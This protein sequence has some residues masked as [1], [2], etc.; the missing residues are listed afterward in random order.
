MCLHLSPEEGAF[1][2]TV[3][4]EIKSGLCRITFTV[5]RRRVVQSGCK[6][7]LPDSPVFFPLRCCRRA[8]GRLLC[9]WMGCRGQGIETSDPGHPACF[10]GVLA[11]EP[12]PRDD[13]CSRQLAARPSLLNLTAGRRADPSRLPQHAPARDSAATLPVTLD[14]TPYTK[15]VGFRWLDSVLGAAIELGLYWIT[16]LVLQ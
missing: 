12:A 9:A 10:L 15:H 14:T 13:W 1:P 7:P 5:L 8:L 2:P 3:A 11:L 4:E 16:F 6:V